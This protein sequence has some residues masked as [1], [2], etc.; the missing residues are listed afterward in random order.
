MRRVKE[1]EETLFGRSVDQNISMTP[2]IVFELLVQASDSVGL[3]GLVG[4]GLIEELGDRTA[5]VPEQ[6][7]K[8]VLFDGVTFV[9]S[10]TEVAFESD[11]VR[12]LAVGE[13]GESGL[14]QSVN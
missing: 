7:R 13:G 2:Q 1:E 5:I 8:P 11:H 4:G 9:P 12:A 14:Q 10:E 6:R 3:E